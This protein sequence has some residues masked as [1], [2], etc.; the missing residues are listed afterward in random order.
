M[1][2]ATLAPQAPRFARD[3]GRF[4]FGLA[5]AMALVLIAGFSFQLAMGR[6]SFGA[7]LIWHVHAVV[8]MTW[9]GLFVT[10][11]WLGARGPVALHRRL[12]WLASGWVLLMIVMGT[13]ITVA[14]V[15]RGTAPFFFQPQHFLIANPLGLLCFAGLTY[16]A[17]R[18]RRQTDWHRRLQLCAFASI[19]GPG[20][21]RLLPMPFMMPVA[22]E[23]AVVAGLIFPGIA[24]LREYR[25][26]GHVHPAWWLGV[27]AIF[28][29]LVVSALVTH[30]PI[31]DAIYAT[32]VAGTPGARL[33]GLAFGAFPPGL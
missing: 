23:V 5:L 31:G 21:G 3:D 30:S 10:Q 9:V 28:G 19:L 8:F 6:S 33:P 24:V 12:G 4:Y 7:P 15:R 22:F 20:F 17:I 26:D 11:A 13:A 16:A 32:T 1:K 27:G 29:T 25:R 18:L 2:M 14:T